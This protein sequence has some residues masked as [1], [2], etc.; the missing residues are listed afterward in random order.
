MLLKAAS[1][2]AMEKDAVPAAKLV[3]DN[4]DGPLEPIAAREAIS[5][6]P[7]VIVVNGAPLQEMDGERWGQAAHAYLAALPEAGTTHGG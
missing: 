6:Q 7:I 4:V 5:V 2:S 3:I 1:M